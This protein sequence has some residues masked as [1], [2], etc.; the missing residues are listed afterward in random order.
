M[1]WQK[2]GKRQWEAKGAKGKFFIEQ[3]NGLY[4]ASYVNKA[5]TYGFKLPP[6]RYLDVAKALC[7][8]NA[9]WEK[10]EGGQK[11]V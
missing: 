3:G 8:S 1:K 10:E 7:E 9:Y 6:R 4:W 11:S 2:V 5:Q